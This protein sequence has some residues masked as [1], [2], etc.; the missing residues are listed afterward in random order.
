MIRLNKE[1]LTSQEGMERALKSYFDQLRAS[2]DITFNGML[3]AQLDSCDYAAR[4]VVLRVETKPWME[5]PSDVV[6]GGVA[7]AML[8]MTMGTLCRYYTGGGMT[9]TV[10]MTVNYLR[11]T[12][13]GRTI[14]LQADL[15]KLGSTLCHTTGKA[16]VEGEPDAPVCTATASYFS[17]HRE[18]QT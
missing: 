18:R 3:G 7:A 4:R 9:P 10:S 14:Y 17:A 6:H 1:D 2:P 15:P 13:V 16:W 12:P 5:N 11:P 8:D